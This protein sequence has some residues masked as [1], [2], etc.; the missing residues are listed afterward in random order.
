MGRA[1]QVPSLPPFLLCSRPTTSLLS[2]TQTSSRWVQCNCN[3]CLYKNHT[4]FHFCLLESTPRSPQLVLRAF[5]KTSSPT[6]IDSL[7]LVHFQ[8]SN[9]IHHIQ[10]LLV[11]LSGQRRKRLIGVGMGGRS[12]HSNAEK[13][14]PW[15]HIH[16]PGTVPS[17]IQ[18]AACWAL[19]GGYSS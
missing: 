11:Y 3:A 13:I 4:P 8:R 1:P 12:D 18:R 5:P 17:T 14:Y 9:P 6:F 10:I 2:S 7:W 19:R 15:F 16:V